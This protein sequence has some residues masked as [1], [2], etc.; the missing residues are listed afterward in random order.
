VQ[1]SGN[2]KAELTVE[3]IHQILII[4]NILQG[5]ERN[6]LARKK[7]ERNKTILR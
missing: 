6:E 4:Q 2:Q 1:A 3:E 5:K 7:T